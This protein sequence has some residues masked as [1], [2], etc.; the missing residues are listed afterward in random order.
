MNWLAHL[1]LSPPSPL[2]RLGNLAGDF[3]QGTAVTA[4][5][6][7]LQQGIALHRAIDRFVDAHPIVQQGKARFAPPFRRFGGVL[8]DVYFDHFLA[9]DFAVLTGGPLPAFLA[10]VHADLQQ[11]LTLLP[12][13]LQRVVPRLANDGWLAG[14][15]DIAG[16]ER[17]LGL[18][19]QRLPRANPLALGGGPLRQHYASFSDDFAALWPALGA[20]VGR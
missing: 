15:A 3:V 14:Y 17:V 10:S 13:P 11:H 5:H 1:V 7:E 19:S 18:M 20:M 2:V 9:R 4:L 8:L 6:P 12:A 16:I